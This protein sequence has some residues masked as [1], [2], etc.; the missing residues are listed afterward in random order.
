M[1][2]SESHRESWDNILLL[3]LTKLL[4]LDANK[5]SSFRIFKFKPLIKFIYLVQ[6]LFV[7]TLSSNMRYND[8]QF[9]T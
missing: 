1:L 9:K 5:V 7:K 4:K 6:T 8:I 2:P 3:L